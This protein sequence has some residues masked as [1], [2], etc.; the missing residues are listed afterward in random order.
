M[1]MN[2]ILQ[3]YSRK[4]A[5]LG[6]VSL[7]QLHDSNPWVIA[8]WSF[9]FP[10]FGYLL[11]G[12]F[13]QGWMMFIWELFVNIH[14]HFNKAIVMAVTGHFQQS[15]GILSSDGHFWILSYGAV[16]CYS[17]FDSYSL[18]VEVNHIY[19]LALAENVPVEIFRISA[20][21]F[22][23]FNKRNPWMAACWSL[24][25]PGL[26][27]L[28]TR[29]IASYVFDLSW[30]MIIVYFSRLLP[31]VLATFTG[32]FQQATAV[33]NVE[34]V[35][36][37]PSIYGFTF[38]TSYTGV[39][40][41]NKLFDQQQANY[42]QDMYQSPTFSLSA[43]EEENEVRVVSTFDH[44]LYLE[45]AILNVEKQGIQKE[46]IFVVPMDKERNRS[47]LSFDSLHRSDGQSSLDVPSLTATLFCALGTIY[48]FELAWGPVFCGLIGFASGF[49]LGLMIKFI[50]IKFTS[51]KARNRSRTEVVVMIDCKTE[52][53]NTVEQILWQNRAFG[54]AQVSADASETRC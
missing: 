20:F 37:V 33:L 53:A 17:L 42:L 23:F 40:E 7:N 29:R 48:G 46:H 28:Y 24:F 41:Q 25:M 1:S 26:G 49:L 54:V 14:A 38:Y 36:F 8:A 30:W 52:L 43:K 18:A 5:S 21:Q 32:H 34:W 22:N 12:E 9:F 45:K 51:T 11:L 10:G 27:G 19:G 35:M 4:R 50:V 47:S 31:A 6:M 2:N 16:F 15:I 13:T 44:N 39:V 3:T